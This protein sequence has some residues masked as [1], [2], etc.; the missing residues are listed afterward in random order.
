MGIKVNE[1]LLNVVPVTAKKVT[2]LLANVRTSAVVTQHAVPRNRA[3]VPVS[4]T[5]ILLKI[6]DYIFLSFT[7]VNCACGPTCACG[8]Q[9]K[10]NTVGC[11]MC[12]CQGCDAATCKCEKDKCFCD[13]ACCATKA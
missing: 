8:D 13:K 6:F 7:T 4:C 10:G 2:E 12:T 3:I 9:C 1:T 11:C 5:M